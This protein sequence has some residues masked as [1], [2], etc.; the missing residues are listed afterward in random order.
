[1][2]A[3][4]NERVTITDGPDVA[5]NVADNAVS[6]RAALKV[7]LW[8]ARDAAIGAIAEA[9]TLRAR[10]AE[11]EALIHQLRVELDR[12]ARVE[13]TLTYRVGKALLAPAKRARQLAR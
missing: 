9:G 4:T 7:E 12:L 1:V 11:L 2:G 10:N 13:T 6:E 3:P 8:V 5:D